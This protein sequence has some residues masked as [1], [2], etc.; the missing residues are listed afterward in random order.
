MFLP[1]AGR[2]IF[3]IYINCCICHIAC[4]PWNLRATRRCIAADIFVVLLFI[5]YTACCPRSLLRMP[6]AWWIAAVNYFIFYICLLLA[7][8]VC[9]P[10]CLSLGVLP[11]LYVFVFVYMPLNRLIYLMR[12]CPRVTR[13]IICW[14][15]RSVFLKMDRNLLFIIFIYIPIQFCVWH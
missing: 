14:S 5:F 6:L 15:F 11:R 1:R 9:K 8:R 13:I 7:A 4:C 2:I 10:H 12:V 3:I